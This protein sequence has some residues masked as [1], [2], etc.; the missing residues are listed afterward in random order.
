MSYKSEGPEEKA[1]K[2]ADGRYVEYSEELADT[3]DVEAQK[4]AKKAD[5]RVKNRR[6]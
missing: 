3:D 4:R 5:D 6:Q 1:L 2:E